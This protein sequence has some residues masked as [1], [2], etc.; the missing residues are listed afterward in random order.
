LDDQAHSAGG[1][2]GA[3]DAALGYLLAA[4]LLAELAVVFFNVVG[5]A[6][7][8]VPLLWSDEAAKLAVGGSNP[9][10][11]MVASLAETSRARDGWAGVR[12]SSAWETRGAHFASVTEGTNLVNYVAAIGV[13]FIDECLSGHAVVAAWE[14][15]QGNS[16]GAAQI[17]AFA[18]TLTPQSPNVPTWVANPTISA[19]A[20]RLMLETLPKDDPS[21]D[22]LD[23]TTY[24]LRENASMPLS[25]EGGP[26]FAAQC[27]LAADITARLAGRHG[28]RK[29][30]GVN[31]NGLMIDP[32]APPGDP[33]YGGRSKGGAVG[34]WRTRKAF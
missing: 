12:C 27:S 22:G 29:T 7:F 6:F 28:A 3:L 16:H 2:P 25:R 15:A 24:W 8:N 17:R 26:D 10:G 19:I 9:D 20:S 34:N 1:W 21:L 4:A 11:E 31:A 14:S 30:P 32:H 18:K 33:R 5:R 23:R 13:D